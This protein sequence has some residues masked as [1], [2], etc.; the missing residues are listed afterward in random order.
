MV[1]AGPTPDE[2]EDLESEDKNDDETNLDDPTET[3]RTR[4]R[5]TKNSSKTSTHLDKQCNETLL[6]KLPN[7][8]SNKEALKNISTIK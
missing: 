6:K 3:P 7:E 4:A 8:F 5:N 2:K 1:K